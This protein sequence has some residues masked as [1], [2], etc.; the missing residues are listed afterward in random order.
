MKLLVT[1][2]CFP[3]FVCILSALISKENH[4]SPGI[5]PHVSPHARQDSFNLMVFTA[6]ASICFSQKAN[7][8]VSSLSVRAACCFHRTI[9]MRSDRNS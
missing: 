7:A 5:Q 1:Y 3:S 4:F 2:C 8:L 9:T 6:V